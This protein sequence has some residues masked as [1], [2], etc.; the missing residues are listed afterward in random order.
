MRRIGR[1]G[2]AASPAYA[3]DVKTSASATVQTNFIAVSFG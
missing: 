2:Y 3:C 1:D